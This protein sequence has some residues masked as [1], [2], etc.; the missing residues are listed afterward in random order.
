MTQAPLDLKSFVLTQR[1]AVARV[2]TWQ[3][4]LD[5]ALRDVVTPREWVEAV[6]HLNTEKSAALAAGTGGLGGAEYRQFCLDLLE[7]AHDAAGIEV[8]HWILKHYIFRVP[9]DDKSES[10][11]AM[12]AAWDRYGAIRLPEHVRLE[13]M[14]SLYRRAW[15][16]VRP[17]A[18][19]ARRRSESFGE[20][21]FDLAQLAVA[22][23][24]V[25]TRVRITN[26][27][28]AGHGRI[29][30]ELAGGVEVDAGGG[31]F[32]DA[33]FAALDKGDMAQAER[34][35]AAYLADVKARVVPRGLEVLGARTE[36]PGEEVPHPV[37][38]LIFEPDG[39]LEARREEAYAAEQLAHLRT[40]AT[41]GRC[42]QE[43]IRGLYL[44]MLQISAS[45][46][47][48]SSSKRSVA[49][50]ERLRQMRARY[51][52]PPYVF[53]HLDHM[54]SADDSGP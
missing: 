6:E 46:S 24:E 39:Y 15:S 54:L 33:R 23:H 50:R 16:R 25:S 12:L 29:I 52:L 5:E 36:L 38:N 44:E 20:W 11:N 40:A 42:S 53:A 8:A 13:V 17:L 34:I 51:E 18:S 3:R 1:P 26:R 37:A 45:D 4:M 14:R 21:L 47:L 22:L 19:Q 31:A 43:T 7:S 27:S 32:A 30:F 28:E 49:A 35:E 41:D 9:D 2:I 48:T 10:F